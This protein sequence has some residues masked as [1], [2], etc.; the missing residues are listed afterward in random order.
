MGLAKE[1]EKTDDD[2]VTFFV[3]DKGVDRVEKKE[4]LEKVLAPYEEWKKQQESGEKRDT[5]KRF[6]YSNQSSS[7]LSGSNYELF[8]KR[9]APTPF[10][11]YDMQALHKSSPTHFTACKVK[12][13]DSVGR[14]HKILPKYPFSDE[15][16][17]LE[18]HG[19]TTTREQF[20]KDCKLIADFMQNCNDD[21][22]FEELSFLVAQNKEAIGWGA[23]EVIRQ[24]DG[25]IAQLDSVPAVRLRV[26]E[27]GAGYVEIAQIRGSQGLTDNDNVVYRYFQRFGDKIKSEADN[28]FDFDGKGAKITQDYRP[29]RD[30]ELNLF[31]NKALKWNLKDK[32]TGEDIE[33]N[34]EN[35][36]KN[37]ANEIIFFAN[38][39]LGTIYYGFPDVFSA[40]PN[41]IMNVGIVNYQKDFFKNSCIP[42]YAVIIKGPKIS[43][44]FKNEI[45]DYFDNNIK[46]KNHQTMVLGLT[47]RAGGK[48]VEIEFK[49]L[50][51]G[52]SE[53][54]FL[55]TLKSNNQE[56][57]T[58]EGVPPALLAV[59]DS[60]SLGSGKG[61]A[62]AELY[63]DRFVIPSQLFYENR[64]NKLFRLGLGVTSAV[65]KFDP[66][67]VRDMY[68]VAQVI[69]LLMSVGVLSIN[70][71]RKQLGQEPIV[72]GDQHFLKLQGSSEV[73]KVED[74]FKATE[75]VVEAVK[76]A[77]DVDI[78][79]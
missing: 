49:E 60:A 69:Q 25:K 59:H 24:A 13:R 23:F 35:F 54:D 3:S 53:A 77:E 29:E 34:A 27:D 56:I 64:F 4:L 72:N 28:P 67:D 14:T 42:R 18:D 57:I 44:D 38:D 36:M 61:L 37:A 66:L 31:T 22:T 17:E 70:E 33:A 30:G 2:V 16:Q 52:R 46:G 48:N 68:Q 75:Q 73:R 32:N 1:A 11:P 9:V 20:R 62:Q 65:I 71:A 79:I 7:E 15:S 47:S 45:A 10:D 43:E 76:V 26:L 5:E 40:I 6:E 78:V 19:D 51:S 50:D 74:L 39:D 63:K 8:R 55:E 21:K 41:L 12:A 58:A